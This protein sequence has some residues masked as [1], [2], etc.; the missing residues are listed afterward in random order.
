M[1][2]ENNNN[3]AEQRHQ[4][5]ERID[6]DFIPDDASP[7]C[8]K[9]LKPCH[10]LQYYCPNCD[11][12]DAINPLTPYIGFVNIRFNYGIFLT[13]W[14]KTWY[15]KDTPM[16]TRVSYLFLVLWC[17]PMFFVVGLPLSLVDKI[18]PPGLRHTARKALYIIAII[19]FIAFLLY[20]SVGGRTVAP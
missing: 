19:L 5:D 4:R 9:C 1:T 11:S 6:D 14:C 17:A 2:G 20:L 10:P 8:L 16:I 13:M 3:P 15:E 7:L 12:N 18:C